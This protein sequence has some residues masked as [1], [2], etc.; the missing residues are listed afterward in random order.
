MD[1]D[2]GA[3]L[4]ADTGAADS[5]SAET[6]FGLESTWRTTVL[7]TSGEYFSNRAWS[8]KPF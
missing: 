2:S 4:E 8:G 6:A 5:Q 1:G 3:M 7:S